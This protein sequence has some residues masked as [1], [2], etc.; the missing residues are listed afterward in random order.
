MSPG[1]STSS[2]VPSPIASENAFQRLLLQIAAKGAERCEANSLIEFFCR[3]TREFFHCSGVYFWRRHAGDELVGE[4]ADGNLAHR[5][6]GLRALPQQPAVS[7]EAV[8]S[9]PTIFANRLNS[10]VFPQ[11]REFDAR[12]MMAAPLVVFDEVIGV[13]VFLHNSESYF[14]HHGFCAESALP[15]AR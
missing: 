13:V 7:A 12:S 3:A 11:A 4:Q 6:V 5:F 1:N 10:A 2:G 8:R 15:G 14:L 9:R